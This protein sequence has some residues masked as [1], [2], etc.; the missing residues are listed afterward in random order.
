M[1]SVRDQEGELRDLL[2]RANGAPD[3][4]GVLRRNALNKLVDTTH[5]PHP[6]LKILAAKHIPDV[7]SDFPDQEEAAI[8]AVYDLCEDQSSTVRKAGYAAITALSSAANKW[9]KRNTD[10]L[11]QLL[12]SDEPDEVDVVKQALLAHL[13]LDARVT[14]SV[15]C[16]QIMPAAEGTTDP[17]ELF[18]RDRLRTLVLAFLTGEA[19]RPIVDRHALPN[20]EAEAV[21]IDTFLAAIPKLSTA[22]TDIIVKQLL[23]DL[24]S[25]R[26]G[27]PRSNA[28]LRTLLDQAQ[29]CFKAEAK[30][31]A[32]VRTRFYMDLMAYVTTEKSLG[33]PL[34]LLRFYLP[35]LVAKMTLL[36]LTPDDQVYVICNMAET[37][38]ACEKARDNSQQLAVLRNQSVDAS[39]NLFECLAKA[40]LAD[41]RARNACKV[42]LGCCLRRKLGGW[43][44]P[45]HLRTSLEFLRSKTEQ[46]KDVQEL[47][48]VRS[49]LCY[50]F[51]FLILERVFL[52][53]V[54]AVITRAR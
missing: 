40:D 20:S 28:L 48:R 32:L 42:L 7:F 33:S 36:L 45:S 39:P 51:S 24:Q 12:Q 43:T 38:A 30:Q 8:N 53:F 52:C 4:S 54:W 31:R 6:S 29:V 23:L 1:D 49:G 47:I 15:L 13:D 9:V 16:D 5:S 11:L 44:V 46:D 50:L 21:L 3:R 22:D 10:V 27:L 26:P 35:S 34:D 25:Y 2:R 19:K 18:M 14:L 41:K 37:F 17:D